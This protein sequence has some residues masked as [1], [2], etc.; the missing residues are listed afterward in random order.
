VCFDTILLKRALVSKDKNLCDYVK[1]ETKKATCI[2]YASA[3]DDNATFKNAIIEK[4]LNL[5]S[6]IGST[7]LKDRCHDSVTLL[8][9]RDTK[10]SALCDTLIA[11]GSIDSCK[12]SIG[13][14]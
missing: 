4:N 5:C 6:S 11:T 12:K 10:N 1:D 2:S 13:V 9:V 8:I 7:S 3:Q 14:Q